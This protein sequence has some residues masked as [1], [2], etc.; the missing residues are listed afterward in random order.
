MKFMQDLEIY[1]ITKYSLPGI[2]GYE[3]QN[4]NLREQPFIF[5]GKFITALIRCHVLVRLK[6]FRNQYQSGYQSNFF[7]SENEEKTYQ[8]NVNQNL[9]LFV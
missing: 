8:S 1:G 2:E 6:F 9:Y 7:Q 4:V 5:F 3:M